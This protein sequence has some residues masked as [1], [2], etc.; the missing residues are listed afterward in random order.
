[1][2]AVV[3][4]C[5]VYLRNNDFMKSI[6][7]FLE[8][9]CTYIFCL[10]N[11]NYKKFENTDKTTFYDQI[12][13]N[14]DTSHTDEISMIPTIVIKNIIHASLLIRRLYPD[15]LIANMDS[16]KILL[17]FSLIYS[18]QIDLITNPHL[19]SEIFDIMI[20]F[21]IVNQQERNYKKSN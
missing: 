10:N 17:Y 5:D 19:R 1:M 21:F 16:T 18:S 11:K 12:F 20:Y 15:V 3:R 8:V 14:I 9:T 7:K 4:A 6:L 2:Y 13:D